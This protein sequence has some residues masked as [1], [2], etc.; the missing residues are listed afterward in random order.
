MR[1][2]KCVLMFGLVLLLI[3]GCSK[4][5]IQPDPLNATDD[6]SLK[7]ANASKKECKEDHFVPFK[8]S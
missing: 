2:L 6:V 7:K 4:E 5:Q 1:E 8:A 3:V